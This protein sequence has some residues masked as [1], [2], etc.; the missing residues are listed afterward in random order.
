MTS[1]RE[2][3]ADVQH[4]IWSDWMRY[5]F[6]QCTSTDDGDGSLVIPVELVLCWMGQACTLYQELSEQEKDSDRKQADKVLA[7]LDEME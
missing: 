2:R 3:L 7:V 6:S 5:L 1:L 4:K